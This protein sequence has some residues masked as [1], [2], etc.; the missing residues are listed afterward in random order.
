MAIAT[1]AAFKNAKPHARGSYLKAALTTT[2]ARLYM[3]WTSGPLNAPAPTT[4]VVPDATTLGSMPG[5]PPGLTAWIK[6]AIIGRGGGGSYIIADRL[7]HQGGLSGIVTGA[8]TTN[9]PTAALT[10]YTSGVGVM[11]ALEISTSVGTTA[12]TA[13]VSYT[14]SAGTAGRTSPSVTFGGA[15]DRQTAQV[16]MVP[17]QAGD[18]GVRSV[19]SVTLAASTA[20]AGAFGVTLYKPLLALP[21]FD[22][23]DEG[24][25][26]DMVKHMGCFFEPIQADA[27][28]AILHCTNATST[29]SCVG[30]VDFIKR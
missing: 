22:L 23:N 28:L 9:L 24:M 30:A 21:W 15:N 20:T 4:A 14:N 29:F 11:A 18:V 25:P 8:Q 7:S 2:S 16:Q 10:R 12:T 17:L 26:F 1:Y 19:E 6:T 27:C 3:R 5:W 13:V